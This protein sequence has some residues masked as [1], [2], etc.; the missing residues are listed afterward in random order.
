MFTDLKNFFNTT[1]VTV[2]KKGGMVYFFVACKKKLW[3]T[4]VKYKFENNYVFLNENF[5]VQNKI[6]ISDWLQ[7]HHLYLLE[8]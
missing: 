2:N 8:T 3:G 1:W 4:I 7:I 5:L 6:I